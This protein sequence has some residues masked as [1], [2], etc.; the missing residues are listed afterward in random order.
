[1]TTKIFQDYET[2]QEIKTENVIFRLTA[3][4]KTLLYEQAKKYNISISALLRFLLTELG[5][6]ELR[7]DDAN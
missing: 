3:T 1:M 5:D 2:P 7:I 6:R 4:E